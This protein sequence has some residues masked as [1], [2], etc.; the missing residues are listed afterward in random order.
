M[1][2]LFMIYRLCLQLAQDGL[3]K[4]LHTHWNPCKHVRPLINNLKNHIIL[5]LGNFVNDIVFTL[6]VISMSNQY[7]LFSRWYIGGAFVQKTSSKDI[8][9]YATL[10]W[11]TINQL[12][13]NRK[14][15]ESYQ[16]CAAYFSTENELK[17]RRANRSGLKAKSG[18]WA[19]KEVLPRALIILV[20]WLLQEIRSASSRSWLKLRHVR[21]HFLST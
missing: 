8:N 20:W 16:I 13:P 7:K 15:N 11:K 3:W 2:Y 21:E 17:N 6:N 5:K 14:S 18:L 12:K 4:P 1:T 9:Q 10:A 19:E